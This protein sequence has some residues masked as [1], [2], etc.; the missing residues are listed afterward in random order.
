MPL[1]FSNDIVEIELARLRP[2][3]RQSDIFGDV[4]E[5]EILALAEDIATNGQREPIH[6]VADGT[7]LAGHE[8]VR[9][10]KSLGRTTI[11]AVVHEHASPDDDDAFV[12]MVNDNFGRRQLGPLGIARCF[13]ALRKVLKSTA[14]IA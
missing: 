6:V 2:N 10:L 3:P 14:T 9:A 12:F 13:V 1:S 5:A 7:I 11:R 8:R 4:S